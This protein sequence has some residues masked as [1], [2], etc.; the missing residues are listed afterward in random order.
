MT[1]SPSRAP[2]AAF[3]WDDPLLLDSQLTEDERMVRD[4]AQ[5]YCQERLAPR[6]LE[7]FRHEKTDP[8]IFREMGALG[9]LGPTIPEQ[10]G[11]PGLNY[12]SYGLIAREVERVDS[13]YRS[14]MSVQS[15]LVMVPIYEFGTEEQRR[16]YLPKL[17]TGEWIGCFGLTEPNHG[18]DPG[19]MET[20][21]KAVPGGWQLTGSKMWISNSPIADV[22]VVWAK[23]VGG[24]HD[25]RIKG[26]ILEK[27]MKGLSAPAIHGKVGL[28]ASI[29]GEVVMDQVFVSNE[30]LMPGVEGLKGPFTCLNSAR[31]GIAWGALG[32]AE[33]CWHR[34]RQ[35]VLDRKQFGRPLAANQLIQKKLADMQ[36]EI[37]LGLQGCLRLGRMKDEGTAAVEITSILKRNSC[38]K[39]LDIARLARDMMGG[40]GISDEF[41]V[42]RHLVNLE[43]VNTYEGTHD[44]H[45]LILGR[46]QTGI[47]AF[48]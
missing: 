24:D 46:A 34:A 25:G 27:G 32:A 12:V 29:T 18:S 21:A 3:K 23:C 5:A 14:M 17:A 10:Y 1:A 7:A 41:G 37:T 44:V 30:Q 31:Y 2:K 43:V 38:G 16:K 36:T 9:M 22:F 19:S 28:R 4:A 48:S 35:Y 39:S 26:F 20:R 13:G 40:N 6:V 45:A 15:S 11:G 47:A 8:A 42:A 33:D